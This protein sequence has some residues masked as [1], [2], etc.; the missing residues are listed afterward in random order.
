MTEPPSPSEPSFASPPPSGRPASG[1]V[2]RPKGMLIGRYR[3]EAELGRGGMGVVLRAFDTGL[4]RPV[5]IKMIGAAGIADREELERFIREARVTAKLRHPGIVAVHEVA[6]HGG[7]PYIVMDLVDGPSLEAVLRDEAPT[8]RRA[9]EIVRDVARGL[10]HAHGHGILHRD[11]KPANVVIDEAEQ[12]PRLTDFGLARDVGATHLTATGDILGTPHYMAP[13]Q[14]IGDPAGLGPATDIWALGGVLYRCL[15]G[16]TPFQ[17]ESALVVL[18]K[19]LTDEVVP[20]AQQAPDV[21]VDLATITMR[22]LEREPADRYAT[23]AALADDLDRWLDGRSIRARPTGGLTKL[24]RRLR[25]RVLELALA[26]AIVAIVALTVGLVRERRSSPA[27]D[28]EPAVV[29]TTAARFSNAKVIDLVVAARAD[30]AVRARLLA[31]LED[32]LDEVISAL[33]E[34]IAPGEL[35]GPAR[36]DVIAYLTPAALG[37]AAG[38]ARTAI[39]D[40]IAGSGMRGFQA[41]ATPLARGHARAQLA[42]EAIGL[43]WPEPEE[44]LAVAR[45]LALATQERDAIHPA[46]ALVRAGTPEARDALLETLEAHP[47]LLGRELAMAITPELARGVGSTDRSVLAEESVRRAAA[48]WGSIDEPETRDEYDRGLDEVVLRTT[49]ALIH[50]PGHV[51][52]RELRS[53]AFGGLARYSES[54][55]D[56]DALVS[57]D[58]SATTRAFRAR[59]RDEIGAAAIGDLTRARQADPFSADAWFGLGI[60][61]WQRKKWGSA[62]VALEGAEPYR[63]DDAPRDDDALIFEALG[64]SKAGLGDWPG[65]LEAFRRWTETADADRRA[66]AWH[67]LAETMLTLGRPEDALSELERAFAGDPDDIPEQILRTRARAL[68]DLGRLD[69]A[70]SLL[71]V[72]KLERHID[73]RTDLGI[74]LALQG[75]RA[76][77]DLIAKAPAIGQPPIARATTAA[78]AWIMQPDDATDRVDLGPFR[79]LPGSVGATIRVIQARKLP[80]NLLDLARGDPEGGTLRARL[81]LARVVLGAWAD[82]RTDDPNAAADHYLAASEL[83]DPEHLSTTWARLRGD[84]LLK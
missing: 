80:P 83:G 81:H 9:A 10:E 7:R 56:A 69:E 64:D 23:A 36:A 48:L 15:S 68:R 61:Y 8:A 66:P 41:R 71:G 5:A 31:D 50:D 78:L 29:P 43:L 39:G 13:E 27:V 18:Q 52:A 12:R 40:R 44:V 34:V 60:A 59:A 63:E 37:G 75:D 6:Q 57:S 24:R 74:V 30:P 51:E 77:A 76:G 53:K 1:E 11:V 82:F 47:G 32:V 14:A 70:A 46:V 42:C 33:A 26:A 28:D 54:L 67:R 84:Q 20:L 21:P 65:A 35:T 45:Y 19:V 73:A 4:Q 25:R 22:C 3:V 62:I 16:A 17:G 2:D 72:A 58:D 49:I 79:T 38:D 55:A